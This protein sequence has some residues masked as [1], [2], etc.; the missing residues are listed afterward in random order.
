MESAMNET[1]TNDLER[2]I[3][4]AFRARDY[5]AL[6][7]LLEHHSSVRELV[8]RRESEAEARA[9]I[10]WLESIVRLRRELEEAGIVCGGRD[11]PRGSD[12]PD[13]PF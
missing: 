10:W 1:S 13:R 5:A 3:E 12:V 11:G 4:R 2:R 6:Y 9:V 7:A 8:E